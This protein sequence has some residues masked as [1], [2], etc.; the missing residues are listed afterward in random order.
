MQAWQEEVS[1]CKACPSIF[2]EIRQPAQAHKVGACTFS[3]LSLNR[4]ILSEHP[5]TVVNSSYSCSNDFGGETENGIV[6]SP[7][8]SAFDTPHFVG[9]TCTVFTSMTQAQGTCTHCSS[10]RGRKHFDTASV[11]RARNAPP[12]MPAPRLLAIANYLQCRSCVRPL[13]QPCNSGAKKS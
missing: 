9:F 7:T 8:P 6:L 3:S 2:H 5:H 10:Q 13:S 11:K 4:N 12:A 1:S